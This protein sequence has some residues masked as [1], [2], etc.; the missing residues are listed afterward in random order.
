MGVLHICDAHDLSSSPKTTIQIETGRYL[1]MTK[2]LVESMHG[3]L[4]MEHMV[5]AC[6]AMTQGKQHL[7]PSGLVWRDA[8]SPVWEIWKTMFS[9]FIPIARLRSLQENFQSWKG[10]ACISSAIV[11]SMKSMLPLKWKF[12]T[13]RIRAS[14][15]WTMSV[16]NQAG[17][18]PFGSFQICFE[19][20]VGLHAEILC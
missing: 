2:L 13:W 12:L 6:Q 5:P 3:E 20:T 8:N 18:L 9:S 15:L 1:G 16:L 11:N 4:F 7:N 19:T 14:S 17:L 10:T